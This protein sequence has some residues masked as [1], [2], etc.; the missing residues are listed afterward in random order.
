M[1]SGTAPVDLTSWDIQEPNLI[2]ALTQ[3]SNGDPSLNGGHLTA[4]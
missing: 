2:T 1:G 3:F 4:F